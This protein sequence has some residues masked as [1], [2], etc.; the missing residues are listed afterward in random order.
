[1]T[2]AETSVFSTVGIINYYAGQVAMLIPTL[3]P[4]AV[5]SSAAGTPPDAAGEPIAIVRLNEGSNIVT[6]W[7]WD[8]VGSKKTIAQVY[9]ILKTTLSKINKKDPSN[10]QELATPIKDSDIK[11]FWKTD[12]FPHFNTPQLQ[13]GSY[14]KLNTL[15]GQKLTYY[16]SGL[17]GMEI[18]E[19]AVRAGQS[20]V[21]E[22]F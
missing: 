21:A 22:Y 6:T 17:N 18:V 19:F 4:Y 14:K 20:V 5:A 15:Q 12:Y 1:M 9:Q 7:S 2:P 3:Q 13:A 11:A 10:Q 8:T 16:I